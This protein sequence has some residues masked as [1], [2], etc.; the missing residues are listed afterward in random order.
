M[1]LPDEST[2][3]LRDPT[4]ARLFERLV[5][6]RG[7]TPT[8]ELAD[9]LGLHV[10]GVRRQLEQLRLAGLVERHRVARGRGRPRDEWSISTEAEPAGAPPSG[11]ADLSR[12]LARAI[13]PSEARL[14]EVERAGEEIGRELAPAAGP[15]LRTSF[16]GALAA[17]GFQPSVEG[18]AEGFT[19]TLGN[20]P[21]AESV[22]E[23]QRVVCNI[24]RGL[25]AGMLEQLEPAAELS[26]FEAKDPD[27]AGCLIGVTAPPG[28]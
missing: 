8:R 3:A 17:L 11:Y 2:A 16:T 7:P 15:D 19:C 23:N 4:R 21:Y 25:T 6:L 1:D 26:V 10:N 14:K 13:T 27:R 12:W 28:A 24:H 18:T 5:E 20:C 9:A 22:R